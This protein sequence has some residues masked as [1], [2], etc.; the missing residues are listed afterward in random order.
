MGSRVIES[1]GYSLKLRLVRIV[2]GDL[3]G[4]VSSPF[5]SPASPVLQFPQ[6]TRSP[7]H[8]QIQKARKARPR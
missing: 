5:P 1:L 7:H 8:A 3:K 4:G 6:T 2:R